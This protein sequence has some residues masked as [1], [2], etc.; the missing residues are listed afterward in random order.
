MS[1]TSEVG[2][3][4]R[5][6]VQPPGGALERMMPRHIHPSSPEYLLF[7]DLVHVP[8][9]RAEHARMCEVLSCVAEVYQL[10]D[11]L[12]EVLETPA[13][14]SVISD[15]AQL[16]GLSDRDAVL[17]EG[18]T[19][20][21][22][23]QT[24]IVGTLGGKPEGRELMPPVPNL[25]F[26]RDL[27]ARA[28]ELLIVGNARKAARRRESAITWAVADHHPLF[29]GMPKAEIS[30]EVRGGSYPLT[31]EGGDILIISSS[32]ALIGA[33]ERTTWSMIVHLADELL[34]AGFSR[35]LVVEMPR[36]RSS[37]HLDT[38]FTMLSW[39][40][41]VVFGP[42]LQPGGSE[43]VN[44][45]RLSRAGRGTLVDD[46][47]GD[48]LDALSGEGYPLS[49]V[50]CGGGHPLHAYREQWTDGANYVALAPGIV[51][52]YARNERTAAAMSEAGFR[53]LEAR[54]FL[55][56]FKRDFQSDA[57]K[58]ISSG[59]RFAIH[60]VGSELSRGRG[61]PRCLTMPI[62]REG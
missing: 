28:G 43:E 37:M 34:D 45:M 47:D 26:T 15:V 6:I 59:E 20:E 19:S 55:Q 49:E 53:S 60:I 38:V 10:E 25:I 61:G 51:L 7:D 29:A 50:L 58:L 40:R 23:A 31:V 24:L 36:K 39:D 57:D 54:E 41:C 17:L 22:L 32:L 5:V 8:Q 3:L 35:V 62:A 44:V 1:V 16:S 12:T 2:P 56:V 14:A 48:L 13:R 11:L 9:A 4:R 46:L 27:A 33:S 18:L 21:E 30:R 52:G 42:I